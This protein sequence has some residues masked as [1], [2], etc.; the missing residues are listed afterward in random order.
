MIFLVE[1]GVHDG[2]TASKLYVST[3]GISSG[4]NDNPPNQYYAAR[5][6]SVGRIERAMFGAGDGVSGGTTTGRSEVGFGNI[7]VLNGTSHG[8]DELI[9]HWKDL[10]FREVVIRSLASDAQPFAQAA[11]RFIGSVEQ[12]VSTNA[13][14]QYDIVLHDRLQNI[15][16]PLLINTYLGTT[17]EGGLGTVEGDVDLKDAIKQKVWG[18]V[19]N[20]RVTDV[21][22]FDLVW[23]VS[24][25]PVVSILVYDGGVLLINDGDV[26]T[27]A[28]LFSTPVD[29]G[30]YTT[31][32]ALGLF[33]TG[34]SPVGTVTADVVE[35]TTAAD[36]TAA[37]IAKR[38][39]Q[40][41]EDMYDEDLSLSNSD[42][43]ALDAINPA[44]CGIVVR[45]TET[46]IDAIMRVLNSVGAWMLPQ[47]NSPTMY[48]IG[49]LDPPDDD[50]PV[51]S[52]DFD[53]SI[54]GNPQRV[55]SG[56]DS[57]GVPCWRVTVRYDQLDTVQQSSDLFGVV[58]ENDP[59]RTQ[60]LGLE[61]RQ[62]IV[63]DEAV[64]T[65]WPNAPTI[66]VDTRLISQAAAA[67][68]AERL[69]ALHGVKRDIWR[70]V[71]PMSVNPQDDPGVG[72]AVEL[73][74]RSGRMGLGREIGESQTFRVLGRVDDFD[75][76]PVLTLT[77][78]G[79]ATLVIT[80]PTA[81]GR[82]AATEAPDAA[83]LTGSVTV[84]AN[85]GTL[86]ATETADA[87]SFTGALT[88]S[89][90]VLH[91]PFDNLTTTDTSGN[92]NTGTI[93]GSGTTL[94]SGRIGNALS[95][96]GNGYVSFTSVSLLKLATA[97]SEITI[98]C[99]IK[100]TAFDM[101]ICSLRRGSGDGLMD[102]VI[103][104]NGVGNANNGKLSIL[105]RDDAN[106][107]LT[108]ADG[109]TAVNDN[110]WHHVAFTRTSG[111]V[112]TV[113]RDGVANGSAI[114][115]MGTSVTPDLSTSGFGIDVLNATLPLFNG[116]ADGFQIYN[117]ALTA[118]E[119]A[120]LASV[121]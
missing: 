47:S 60:Y 27:L 35:G 62:A 21:N 112:L 99:W 96:N 94:V 5:M 59:I 54:G 100:T 24:D 116:Q 79:S 55:E 38:M 97:T 87:A 18:T 6:A 2:E 34:V 84:A 89:G 114:D 120:T 40:W 31:C 39:L 3:H 85:Q 25:G 95:F 17:T 102:F 71:V 98:C 15:D 49:R 77:V 103:G 13:L 88:I 70:I 4:P 28:G 37:Q 51:A 57:K 73:T 58:T 93:G 83:A 44:E 115:T 43:A 29:G 74:S 56:D 36:R 110:N 14:E 26:A 45:D 65:V 11:T 86:A 90:L 19:H 75:E 16:K 1:F 63:E 106:G 12:L 117:R 23:Q 78:W 50:E 30:H 105:V 91:Y 113:Y 48:N 104:Y 68:E 76:V 67:A 80:V 64:L 61:W 46:A 9:D 119:I 111:K 42:V 108:G 41:F 66:Q 53:D 101:V 32:N 81:T 20:C 22:H 52:Y 8:L 109:L 118:T 72:E 10:A 121:P 33:R 107:G 7:S 69:L 82:L 92:N